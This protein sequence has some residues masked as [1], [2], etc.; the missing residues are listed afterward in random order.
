MIQDLLSSLGKF[1][2][3][4]RPEKQKLG[5]EIPEQALNEYLAYVL[6]T[7]PRPG[8]S[9]MKVTLLPGNQVSSEVEIDFDAIQKWSP[10]IFPEALRPVLSG[11][12]TIKTD[13]HFESSNGSWSF[14]LKDS[15]GPD[16]K[17]M[18]GKLMSSLLQALGS[19]QPE[20]IDPSKSIPLPFGL[21]RV[22]TENQLLCGET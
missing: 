18:A 14:T 21:K 3:E 4:G 16:G 9:A 17:A 13:A 20:S 2:Q 7:K 11:K 15:M 19:R 22:W 10:E 1:D 5:F 8:I 12:R 6:R